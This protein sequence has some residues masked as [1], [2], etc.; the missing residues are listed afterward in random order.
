MMTDLQ[1]AFLVGA[2][3][4]IGVPLHGIKRLLQRIAEALEHRYSERFRIER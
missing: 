4:A 2:I 3:V 1:F